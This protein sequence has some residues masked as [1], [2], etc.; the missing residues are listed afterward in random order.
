MN[1]VTILGPELR[2]RAESVKTGIPPER[3]ESADSGKS[4]LHWL[5]V[6]L[7]DVLAPVRSMPASGAEVLSLCSRSVV[8][9]GCVRGEV[10]RDTVRVPMYHLR[11]TAHPALHLLPVHG[12][13]LS[14]LA[15]G[16]PMPPR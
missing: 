15:G 2:R 7:V 12:P 1:K 6:L 13:A 9:P 5:T 11:Y 4:G 10:P 16:S 8:Y 14:F 3:A